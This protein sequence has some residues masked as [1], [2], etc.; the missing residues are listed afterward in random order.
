MQNA[1]SHLPSSGV[2]SPGSWG[3]ERAAMGQLKAGDKTLK[4]G[5]VGEIEIQGD[6]IVLGQPFAFNK[7]NI[8]QFDF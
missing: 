1:A 8:G 4:A 2:L 6:N 7:T 5:A 3:T